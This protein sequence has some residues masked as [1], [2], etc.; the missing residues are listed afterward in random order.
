MLGAMHTFSATGEVFGVCANDRRGRGKRVRLSELHDSD[1]VRIGVVRGVVVGMDGAPLD[2]EAPAVPRQ[3]SGS[4]LLG[5]ADVQVVA[6]RFDKIRFGIGNKQEAR[7][8]KWEKMIF[9]IS[10]GKKTR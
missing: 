6:R 2:L 3:A 7:N 8:R 10:K 1:I 9:G 4:E 5:D